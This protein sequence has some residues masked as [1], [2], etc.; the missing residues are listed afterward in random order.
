MSRT[1]LAVRGLAKMF[2][3]IQAV[4]RVDL[5]LTAGRIALLLGENGAG[6]STAIR[7]ALGFLRKD[8]GEVSIDARAIGYVPEQPAYF[9][10][11]RGR[12]LLE[13][14]FELGGIPRERARSRLREWC[15]RLPFPEEL[16]DRRASSYSQGNR[17]K[18]AYLQSLVLSPDLFIADEPFAA[19]DPVAIRS[20]RDIFRE[21]RAGGCGVLLSS[22][23]IA[24]AGRVYDDLVVIHGGTTVLR[25]RRE[26]LGAGAD[27]EALFLE[28]VG[29]AG[30]GPK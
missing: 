15:A 7:T 5:T 17:K 18:L 2:G 23:L 9:P 16:L 28:T 8:G 3:D 10:W 21:L 24:E 11:A 14:A 13:A 26:D 22:H 1:V 20:V 4:R 25:T 29:R 19:L 27:L 12:E 30:R 6:K